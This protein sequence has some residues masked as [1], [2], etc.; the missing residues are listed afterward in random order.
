V[1]A[2]AWLIACALGGAFAFADVA[3]AAD[4]P[5]AASEAASPG[6]AP[7]PIEPIPLPAVAEQGEQVLRNARR[8]GELATPLPEVQQIEATLPD[9]A[10]QLEER[11]KRVE[12]LATDPTSLIALEEELK[13][14]ELAREQLG[15]SL[16]L[17]T[18]RLTELEGALD[19]LSR[20]RQVWKATERA[21]REAVAP[22]A[23]L[24][25]IKEVRDTLREAKGAVEKRRDS[26]L[27]LQ[28]QVAEEE[29]R[30]RVAFDALTDARKSFRSLIL[31]RDSAPLWVSALE[32]HADVAPDL[33]EALGARWRALVRFYEARKER[34]LGHAVLLLFAL[35]GTLALRRRASEWR[36]D[37]PRLEASAVVFE[38]PY[39][40]ALLLVAALTP[41]LH[42]RAPRLADMLGV[43][44]IVVP[45]LRLLP[46]L[47]E[48]SLVPA[49][50]ALA[51][52]ATLDR[53]RDVVSRNV[54]LERT[55]LLLEALA[56]FA[57]LFWMLR[58]ARL[59]QL[60]A[61]AHVPRAIGSALRLAMFA[62][63]V[64]V[65]A[66]FLGWVHLGRALADG[67]LGSAYAAAVIY[68]GVRVVR[69][70]VR[71][72]LRSDTARGLGVVQR[73]G[74]EINRWLRR[75]I[76][77]GAFVGWAYLT[78]AS[79][80]I[81]DWV[82][83][84]I[85]RVLGAEAEFGAVGI[86]LGDLL[87]FGLT[88]AG[89]VLLGR[90]LRVVLEDELVPR[91]PAGRGVGYALTTTVHYAVLLLG[92]LLAVSAA[93]V[94]LDKISLLAGAFGVGIGFGLQ[95]VVNNFVSGLILLYERPVQRGDLVEVGGTTGEV[96]RIGI[97]SST[98]RTFQ[99]AEVIV[100]N[101]SLISDRVVNWTFSD[102]RRRM[103]IKV[104]VAYGT[105]PG[106]VLALLA[107]VAKA[108]PDVLDDPPPQALML[109]FGE[110]S[111]DFELRAWT[112]LYENSV[113]TQSE[114]LVAIAHA[115]GEAAIEVPFPQR[116]L[117]LRSAAPEAA[118]ALRGERG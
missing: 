97:R 59:T 86:S 22:D 5:A 24:E 67:V 81:E 115:L 20:E 83:E 88:L 14:W 98:I 91:L 8:L 43:L 34:L 63:G 66:T 17:L 69:T 102:R 82:L 100:P 60:P 108:H 87:A 112:A 55:L 104:G 84:S 114:L 32:G 76:H 19:D 9:A 45:A 12:Q 64:S 85:D 92:F 111:L 89:A 101:S 78:L 51:A 41:L 7:A 3:H 37:D 49:V 48:P 118:R 28:A 110:S 93:G 74:T 38:R 61:G 79:F 52:F 94:D 68:G 15:S 80:G 70:V 105:D 25:R 96:R 47:L 58:P 56:A 73:H 40:A 18:D 4:A 10:A 2:L 30:A 65:L 90:A 13:V 31:L 62:L 1:C 109:G 116:D 42:P 117:H 39:S 103:E 23:V 107:E 6:P 36:A 44:L 77:L 53:L 99:G 71:A 35:A 46:R 33:R 11:R 106:R 75:A 50:Y 16:T 26:L 21:A 113:A 29:K 72:G 95:N 57:L 27:S 54:F